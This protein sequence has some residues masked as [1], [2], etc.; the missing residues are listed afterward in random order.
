MTLSAKWTVVSFFALTSVAAGSVAFAGCTVTS[1]NP[2]DSDSGTP[3]KNPNPTPGTDSGTGD[4]AVATT[5]CE[6]NK[7]M[8]GDIVG[9]ACQAKLNTACCPELKGCFDIV[10]AADPTGTRGTDNCD[11]YRT[12]LDTCETS[13]N[14]GDGGLMACDSDCVAL[15]QDSVVEAYNAILMCAMTNASDVCK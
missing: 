3:V 1:G 14:T 11:K 13:G 10:L 5:T 6:G 7:Q 2:V 9:P 4:S 15:T 8:S 12:C